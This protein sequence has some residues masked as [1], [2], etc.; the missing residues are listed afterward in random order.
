MSPNFDLFL[1]AKVG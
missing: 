1:Y